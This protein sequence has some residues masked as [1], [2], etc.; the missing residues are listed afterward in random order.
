MSPAITKATPLILKEHLS[1]L[2]WSKGLRERKDRGGGLKPIAST[3]NGFRSVMSQ[4]LPV[5]QKFNR[6][7]RGNE[8]REKRKS[9]GES[10]L[11]ISAGAKWEEGRTHPVKGARGKRNGLSSHSISRKGKEE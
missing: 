9:R 10:A 1:R 7:K 2:S 5:K 11:D 8:N 6:F 4:S 3:Q